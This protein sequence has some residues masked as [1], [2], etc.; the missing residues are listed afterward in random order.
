MEHYYVRPD[1]P[2]AKALASG[3]ARRKIEEEQELIKGVVRERGAADR[4]V[5]VVLHESR[6]IG[7]QKIFF[8]YDLSISV[9][10]RTFKKRATIAIGKVQDGWWVTN[11][12]ETDL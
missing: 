5:A 11:F 4:E 3:L 9:D 2:K 10:H 1:L 8:V 12:H 6:R 7:E